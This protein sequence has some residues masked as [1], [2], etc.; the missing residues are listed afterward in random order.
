MRACGVLTHLVTSTVFEEEV[1]RLATTLGTMAPIAVLG[2]KKHLNLIAR[3]KADAAAIRADVERSL[4]S[5]DLA[6]GGRAWQEKR[7]PVFT[8]R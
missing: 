1:Q 6:E 3:G 7:P 8:G 5:E 4:A 2:M